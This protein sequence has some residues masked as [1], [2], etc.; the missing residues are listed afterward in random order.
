LLQLQ[1]MIKAGKKAEAEAMLDSAYMEA[2][3]EA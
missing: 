3:D 1:D 2:L